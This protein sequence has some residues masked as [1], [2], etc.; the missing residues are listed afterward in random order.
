MYSSEIGEQMYVK[1]PGVW[2]RASSALDPLLTCLL[3]WSGPKEGAVVLVPSPVYPS[4]HPR[5][6]ERPRGWGLWSFSVRSPETLA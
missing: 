6:L 5:V 2:R 4:G 3:N 1:S